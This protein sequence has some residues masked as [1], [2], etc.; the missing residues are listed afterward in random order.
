MTAA[1]KLTICTVLYVVFVPMALAQHYNVID[2]GI[3]PGD[4]SSVGGW[5]NN[6]GHV[7]GCSDPSASAAIPCSENT[8]G[9]HAFLWTKNKGLVDLGTLPGGNISNGYGI[10]DSDE[11]VG[12]SYTNEGTEHGYRW[13]HKTGMQDLGTLPGGTFSLAAALNSLGE[14]VGWSDYE[15]SAGQTDA[16]MWDSHGKIH[17][18]GK[19]P[20]ALSGVAGAINNRRHVVGDS[21]FGGGVFHAIYW[22]KAKGIQDLG[23]FSGGTESFAGFI[24]NS[25]LIVGGADSANNPGNLH[26]PCGIPS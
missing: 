11:A 18:L 1:S 14:I 4:S 19:L 21:N 25:G 23:A 6:L 12:Y 3:L 9:E 2:L 13:T 10:S 8:D 26:L 22:T 7:V 17:D 20:G 24:N 15:G 16:V 5:I